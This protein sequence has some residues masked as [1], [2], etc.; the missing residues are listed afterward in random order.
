MKNISLLMISVIA[1]FA[2][3]GCGGDKTLFQA[4]TFSDKDKCIVI[5]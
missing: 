3:S 4:D 1:L 5:I 2:I